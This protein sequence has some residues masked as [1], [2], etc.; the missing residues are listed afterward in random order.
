MLLFSAHTFFFHLPR[1]LNV[2]LFMPGILGVIS[3][4]L[5]LVCLSCVESLG[6]SGFELKGI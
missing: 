2:I 5:E 1:E 6:D 4:G 3:Y